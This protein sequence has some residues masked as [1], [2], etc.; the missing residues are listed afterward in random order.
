M[1]SNMIA[2]AGPCAVAC[3][4]IACPILLHPPWLPVLSSHS[5][6]DDKEDSWEAGLCGDYLQYW[7]TLPKS[8]HPLL[9][10][11]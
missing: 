10:G 1:R 7:L 3:G 4:R 9:K 11:H 5:A 8:P 6:S 2:D